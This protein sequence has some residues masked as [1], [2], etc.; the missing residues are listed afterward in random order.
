VHPDLLA[1]ESLPGAAAGHDIWAERYRDI[2]RWER[3]LVANGIH[4]VKIMLNLSRQEQAKRFLKRIDRPKNWKLCTSAAPAWAMT[5]IAASNLVSVPA[6]VPPLFRDLE[7]GAA[8]TA[9]RRPA[10]GA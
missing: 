2:N 10:D 9:P 4:V 3:Y 6:S 1:A 8:R 7:P 5:C